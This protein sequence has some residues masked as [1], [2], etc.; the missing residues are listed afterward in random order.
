MNRSDSESQELGQ[1]DLRFQITELTFLHSGEIVER[2]NKVVRGRQR[3]DVLVFSNSPIR[4]NIA[5]VLN[6]R[7]ESDGIKIKDTVELIKRHSADGKFSYR[8]YYLTVRSEN[9]LTLSTVALFSRA[10]NISTAELLFPS[11]V[12]QPWTYSFTEQMVKDKIASNIELIRTQ[13]QLDKKAC[14]Q[15]IDVGEPTYHKI[16]RGVQNLT[17]DTIEMIAVRLKLTPQWLMFGA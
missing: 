10:L 13:R 5:H 2:Y 7:R 16:R 11:D 6:T 15:L 12:V 3:T 4:A 14:A 17:L 8:T 9:N 1:R